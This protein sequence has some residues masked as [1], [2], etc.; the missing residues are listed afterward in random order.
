MLSKVHRV[1]KHLARDAPLLGGV[2]TRECGNETLLANECEQTMPDD[3][4]C[5]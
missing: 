5:R 3:R 1:I 4:E 2:I